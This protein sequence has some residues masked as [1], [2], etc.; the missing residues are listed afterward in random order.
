MRFVELIPEDDRS[1][2]SLHPRLTVLRGMAD[3]DRAGLAGVLNAV[4]AGDRPAWDGTA[5]VHGVLVDVASLGE[6]VGP[7]DGEPVISGIGDLM[8]P[9]AEAAIDSS[10]DRARR[11]HA[12]AAT[13]RAAIEAAVRDHAAEL[14]ETTRAREEVAERVD[15]SDLDIIWSAASALDRA[16]AGL[17]R[18]AGRT[19]MEPFSTLADPAGRR[20]DL[21]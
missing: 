17:R 9:P 14:E 3:R 5:D 19:G 7:A 13:A 1:P 20:Q 4:A 8:P 15:E 2:I 21:E 16:D 11:A 10:R 18:A 6:R 12:D